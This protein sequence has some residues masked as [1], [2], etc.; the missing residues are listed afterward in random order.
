MLVKDCM[1]RHPIMI[2]PETPAAEA[3]KIMAENNIRH[4]PV[5]GAGKRLTGLITRERLTLKPDLLGSLNVW[6]ITRFLS[7]MKVADLMIKSKD[8]IVIA[9]EKTIE[10]A[11][12]TMT[13]HEIGCLPVIEDKIVIGML[14]KSD[15]LTSFEEMLGLPADGVRVTVRMPNIPGEFIKLTTV[16][17]EQN[18]GIMGVGTFPAPREPDYYNAVLK[19]PNANIDE[20]SDVLNKIPDQEV[21]DIRIIV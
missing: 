10:R 19:I 16:L 11:A 12:H 20:V 9:T 14:T 21:I 8:V 2:S 5:V 6:E 13:T 15:L 7:D 3:Q 1:T 17:G 18:W 4:L